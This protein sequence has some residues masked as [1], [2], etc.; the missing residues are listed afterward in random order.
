MNVIQLYI[1]IFLMIMLVATTFMT[2]KQVNEI[3][4]LQEARRRPRLVT[5]EE[6]EGKAT[7]RDYKEGDYVGLVIG[8]CPGG[9]PKRVIGIYA[10]KEERKGRRSPF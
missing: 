9:G 3:R 7:A 6:C 5:V 4:R 1:F 2:F 10:I 8:E